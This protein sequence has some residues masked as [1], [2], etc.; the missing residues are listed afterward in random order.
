M[1]GA[2]EIRALKCVSGW[3][4]MLETTDPPVLTF[5]TLANKEKAKR[6]FHICSTQ[7]RGG[8]SELYAMKVDAL[9]GGGCGTLRGLILVARLG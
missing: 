2:A 8:E 6:A 3:L 5:P 1:F 7:G 9:I 4:K